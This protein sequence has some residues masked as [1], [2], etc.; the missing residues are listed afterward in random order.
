MPFK[1]NHKL[2]TG[3]PKGSK[4]NA[5]QNVREN[6]QKLVENNLEQLQKDI[7]V[8]EPYERIKVILQMSK[9]VLPQLRAIEINQLIPKEEV[10]HYTD[11]ELD[12][13]ILEQAK[14]MGYKIEKVV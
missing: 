12:Q 1:N 13:R 2:S 8:L 6:F 7:D 11:E 4:N 10:R 5:S 14:K 9:F 3:R